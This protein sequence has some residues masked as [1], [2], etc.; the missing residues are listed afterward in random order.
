MQV[1]VL[2][3]FG[4]VIVSYYVLCRDKKMVNGIAQGQGILHCYTS[5]N[6][7]LFSVTHRHALLHFCIIFKIV[8]GLSE[9]T[10]Q[11]SSPSSKHLLISARCNAV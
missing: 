5:R 11:I 9:I 10:K 6:N 3:K 2:M 1:L 7:T 4:A 8:L